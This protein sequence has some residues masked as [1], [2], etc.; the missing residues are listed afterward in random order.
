VKNTHKS[1]ILS[2]LYILAAVMADIEVLMKKA[3]RG[4]KQPAL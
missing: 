3:E 1:Y 2:H 4:S